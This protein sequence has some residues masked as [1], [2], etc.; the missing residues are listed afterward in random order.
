MIHESATHAARHSAEG[1]VV[2]LPPTERDA[3]AIR[4]VL[5]DGGVDCLVHDSM[6]EACA[7]IATGAGVL[8]VSEEALLADAEYLN[9]LLSRQPVW[10]DLPVI[11][12]SRSGSES[13]KLTSLLRRAGNVL[14]V[15][16]PV[17]VSTFLSIVRVALRGRER[18]Y[19]VRAHLQQL[20][21]VEAERTMLWEAERA[22]RTEAER[23][24]RMK[25][26][27]LATLSH[28]IRTPLNAIL[29]WTHIL[30]NGLQPA[31]QLENGLRVI[32]RNA[33]AQSQIIA[34]LLDMNRI[35]NGKVRLDVQR[36]HP[37]TVVQ[38][39]LDT[40]GPAANAKGVEL[41]ARLGDP[42]LSTSGDPARL[43]QVFWNLLSNA[44]KFTPRGGS[45]DVR[46]ESLDAELH[47]C[48]RDTGEGIDSA[49]LPHV[50]DRFSQGDGSTTRRYGGLGLGLAIV[51]QLVELHGGSVR[52]NSE[53]PGRG[54]TFT[55]VLP[56]V[57]D[58][59]E[60]CAPKSFPEELAPLVDRLEGI[61][62]AHV[63]VVD[64]ELDSRDTIRL[65]LE[66]WGALV[67]TAESAAQALELLPSARP[68][69]LVSDIGMPGRDG[70]SLMREIRAL[71]P[72]LGGNTAAIALTAYAR[73]EDRLNAM[74]AGFQ[75]HIA[76]PVEPLELL[77]A[78]ARA[79]RPLAGGA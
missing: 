37:A 74:R 9:T 46:L 66:R 10:S 15:E 45:V 43:Q 72:E 18:Q 1:R 47:L 8:V 55:V 65:L 58:P 23:A 21:A 20:E 5:T 59:V 79:I 11:V 12:L 32:E 17:R 27:F 33:R 38:A 50:F 26:E 7:A 68:D 4:A 16:R 67:T 29:G 35:V 71:P 53:G 77:A 63:L 69:V 34:D 44:V 61:A 2:L 60:S 76:K 70:Y 78:L 51:K 31:G 6:P 3:S 75:Q 40:I 36:I 13:P 14:V 39:A 52:A 56:R 57:R 49:F 42:A 22:A 73:A 64:D 62:G 41:R 24:G 25:D 48:V 30:A 19:E 54:A 28:E